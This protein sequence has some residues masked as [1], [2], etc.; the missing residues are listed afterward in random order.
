MIHNLDCNQP[1]YVY[2]YNSTGHYGLL[3]QLNTDHPNDLHNLFPHESFIPMDFL[4]D[5]HNHLLNP[6]RQQALRYPTSH[7]GF[8]HNTQCTPNYNPLTPNCIKTE[9]Q[10]NIHESPSEQAV[11]HQLISS[12]NRMKLKK[13]KSINSNMDKS[14]SC[15]VCQSRFTRKDELRRHEKIH[16]GIKTLTC[17]YCD[18]TFIRSDHR[19]THIRTHTG[20]KPYSC[21]ICLKCFARSDERTRHVRTHSKDPIR[22]RKKMCKSNMGNINGIIQISDVKCNE[23]YN[24]LLSDK[25]SSPSTVIS[26]D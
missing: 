20:E 14:F 18:K 16:T 5:N 21:E 19:R 13:E 17:P 23:S 7:I 12:G 6:Y 9:S 1:N 11:L 2:N 22:K 26:I 8:Y 3:H 24:H 4:S 25:S 10:S 15:S